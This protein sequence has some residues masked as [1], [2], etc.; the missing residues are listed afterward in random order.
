MNAPD[1]PTP[2]EGSGR[3][4][5]PVIGFLSA[6]QFLTVAPAVIRRPFTPAEMGQAVG[7][8]PLVGLVLGGILL[9]VRQALAGFLPHQVGAALLL[10]LWVLLTGALH[11]DGFLDSCDGLFGGF[12]P[13]RR[14]EIMRDECVGAFALAGGILLFLVKFAALSALPAWRAPALLLAPTLGRWSM[15]L[16]IWL[17]PYA[18][19][20]GLG[21]DMKDHTGWPQAL[22]ATLTALGAAWFSAGGHG[23]AA[24][25]VALI[26]TLAGARFAMRRVP[27]LTG[28]LYGALNEL[29]EAAVLVAFTVQRIA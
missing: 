7:Y 29:V 4:P 9:A 28:D 11:M 24:A 12:T 10:A 8:Y 27:G 16:A 17:F 1:S 20:S 26:V 18:R 19:P 15:S 13:E 21:R 22:L 5:A 3:L 25:G 6:L 23:L 14:L 2:A